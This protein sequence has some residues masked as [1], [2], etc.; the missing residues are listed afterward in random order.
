MP[1]KKI[2]EA[3]VSTLAVMG[4][5][6]ATATAGADAGQHA[7]CRTQGAAQTGAQSRLTG[8]AAV[9]KPG[10]ECVQYVHH[11]HPVCVSPGKLIAKSW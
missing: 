6:M 1:P 4:S 2:I 9:A 11:S 10:Q 7:H 3:V 5:S 8:V